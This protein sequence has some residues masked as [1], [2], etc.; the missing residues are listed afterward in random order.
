[1]TNEKRLI[2]AE[3]LYQVQAIQTAQIAPDG[4]AVVFV[5]ERV[6]RTTEKKYT[7]LWLAPT[8]RN[9]AHQITHGD[10]SDSLPRW[11]P[12][13]QTI[14][15][16]SNRA[17]EKNP[18]VY[19]MPLNGGDSRPLTSGL[20]GSFSALEWSP[21]GQTLLTSF[22]KKDADVIEREEDEA[23]GKLGVVARH[24]TRLNYKLDAFGYL[25]QEQYHIWTIDATSGETTQLTEGRW[26]ETQPTWAPDGQAILFTSNRD[27]D[28]DANPDATEFYEISTS[29]GDLTQI[30]TG[31]DTFKHNPQYS[32]DGQWIAYLGHEE[33]RRFDMNQGLY[34][35][36]RKGGQAKNLTQAHD[37]HLENTTINDIGGGSPGSGLVWSPD[38]QQ[39]YIQ[40]GRHGNE[41]L[42]TI[43]VADGALTTLIDTGGTHGA[44]TL[45]ADGTKAATVHGHLT[46]PG[47]IYIHDLTQGTSQQISKLN[48]WLADVELARIE[49]GWL[50]RDDNNLPPLQYWIHY[51]PDF[52]SNKTYPSIMDVHG[53]PHAQYG[54]LFFHETHYW[55]AQGY[56]VYMTNPRGSQG[57]GEAFTTAIYNC[58]GTVD[59]DD[60]MAIV[61]FAEQLPYIDAKRMGLTGGSY[62]GWMTAEV[63][64]RTDRFA[65]TVA[66][67]V[68]TNWVSMWG[69]SDLNWEAADLFGGQAPWEDMDTYVQHSPIYRIQ[70]AVTPTLVIHSEQ[71]LRCQPEQGEQLYVSLR[72]LGVD[73]E[74]VL[75]PEEPHGLSRMGRTDRRI[76]R[77]NHIVRWFDRYLKD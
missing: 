50:N 47:Q 39:I 9:E 22:R 70:N 37:L 65:A 3:D 69:S 32:P 12:D 53:G 58:W 20:K 23:K 1:M 75:F 21:D 24:I 33:Q 29:G 8:D 38:G 59:Y 17:D 63:I 48:G 52:D 26:A 36:P 5:V 4:S 14:A 40:A 6:D 67:R 56:V 57:Y 15:F 35:V 30:E 76:V 49:T 10:H 71:D 41:P 34:I 72:R 60:V 77:L 44:L 28:P 45:S 62:G 2:T 11:S 31:Y 66:Q 61:D 51:P 19:L 13:G 25:P 42:Q 43:R 55:A 7:D 16:I 74:L 46:D 73:T 27:E 54:N 64:G 18:Q 68:V